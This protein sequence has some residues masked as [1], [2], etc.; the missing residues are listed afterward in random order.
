MYTNKS[1][2]TKLRKKSM[3]VDKIKNTLKIKSTRFLL[4]F[5]WNCIIIKS[6]CRNVYITKIYNSTYFFFLIIPLINVTIS[7]NKN[8]SVLDITGYKLNSYFLFYLR[9]VSI[10]IFHFIIFFFKK[11]KFK[12][13]GYYI[14]KSLRNTITPQFGYSHRIYIYSYFNFIKFL[15][16]TKLL[17]FGLNKSDILLNS[18]KLKS[19]RPINIFTSRGVR[20]TSEIIYKKTGKVSSYK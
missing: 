10:Y 3:L 7:F 9:Y 15:T 1:K 18:Y 8:L 17:I 5:K 6:F 14:Y 11:I 2:S 19:K 12:G 13:K 4:P 16:K 20:F